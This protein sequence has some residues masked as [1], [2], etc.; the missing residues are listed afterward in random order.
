MS[1]AKSG[2]HSGYTIVHRA[3]TLARRSNF[4]FGSS[5]R[6]TVYGFENESEAYTLWVEDT[7]GQRGL[8]PCSTLTRCTLIGSFLRA[9]LGDSVCVL[10]FHSERPLV[11]DVESEKQDG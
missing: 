8:T 9:K 1:I 6:C 10:L 4:I 7:N 5:G 11:G 3:R 2:E